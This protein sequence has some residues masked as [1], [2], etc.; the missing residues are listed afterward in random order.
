MGLNLLMKVQTKYSKSSKRSFNGSKVTMSDLTPVYKHDVTPKG[1]VALSHQNSQN[2][3]TQEVHFIDKV[4]LELKKSNPFENS[5]CLEKP[6][7]LKKHVN[8]I[9]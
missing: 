7:D 9:L 4:N 1:L 5:K 2:K 8:V 3:L 6:I